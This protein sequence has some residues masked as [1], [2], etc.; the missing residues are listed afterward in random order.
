MNMNLDIY[1][2]FPTFQCVYYMTLYLF[3]LFSEEKE[4]S[5]S[6]NAISELIEQHLSNLALRENKAKANENI[7][8][9]QIFTKDD[10]SAPVVSVQGSVMSS[11]DT[12]DI[13]IDEIL[14]DYRVNCKSITVHKDV[15]SNID[16]SDD[17]SD[18]E[19]I[20]EVIVEEL[21]GGES[22]S[23]SF[24][25]NDESKPVVLETDVTFSYNKEY[26]KNILEGPEN[27]ISDVDCIN[28]ISLDADILSSP[29]KFNETEKISPK[30]SSEIIIRSLQENENSILGKDV[31]VDLDNLNANEHLNESIPSLEISFDA[32]HNVEEI[33]NKEG[34]FFDDSISQNILG[35]S[36][37]CTNDRTD[38]HEIYNNVINCIADIKSDISNTTDTQFYLSENPVHSKFLE[39]SSDEQSNYVL[40]N[41]CHVSKILTNAN[42]FELSSESDLLREKENINKSVIPSLECIVPG[43]A[44]STIKEIS[45]NACSTNE[46]LPINHTEKLKY[47]E[48][49][50]ND[51]KPDKLSETNT[52][53]PIDTQLEENLE[54][55]VSD[56]SALINVLDEGS[57]PVKNSVAQKVTQS[58]NSSNS[59]LADLSDIFFP[60]VNV[61]SEITDVQS[62]KNLCNSESKIASESETLVNVTSSEK[63]T[64]Y[65]STCNDQ[66]CDNAIL[67]KDV[68]KI[69]VTPASESDVED[70]LEEYLRGQL[71]HFHSETSPQED[72]SVTSEFSSRPFEDVFGSYFSGD[73]SDYIEAFNFEFENGNFFDDY[74]DDYQHNLQSGVSD[75]L[76]P[77]NSRQKRSSSLPLMTENLSDEESLTV[78]SD[79]SLVYDSSKNIT[80]L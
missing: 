25:F 60:Q 79:S 42:K 48:K 49:S 77:D 31:N 41:T 17:S 26:M 38:L 62:T 15:K 3:C 27:D 19:E 51:Y 45:E 11:I 64:L 43:D 61:A 29:S 59:A 28:T 10:M 6:N 57:S 71:K 53:I 44:S 39:S 20:E 34:T 12:E 66:K 75:S 72:F 58:V 40:D 22:A 47:S 33:L 65:S 50:S 55:L 5:V 69:I 1:S 67:S 56:N 2:F 37:K 52:S 80:R 68:P 36:E 4:I 73:S 54:N 21:S 78:K 30:N 74:I 63:E 14:P 13:V 23:D 32:S 76:F 18:D 8:I 46:S 9:S 24:E 35:N 16:K 70:E 7:D